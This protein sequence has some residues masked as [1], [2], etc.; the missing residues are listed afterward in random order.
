MVKKMQ[1]Q[2][3]GEAISPGWDGQIRLC[4][5]CVLGIQFLSQIMINASEKANE[6][7][8]HMKLYMK[9]QGQGWGEAISPGWDGEG[10]QVC[11]LPNTKVQ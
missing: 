11:W 10:G 1:G 5:A 2:G 9:M 8:M 3:W 6:M 4:S 7:E